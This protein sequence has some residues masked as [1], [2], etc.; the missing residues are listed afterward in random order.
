MAKIN[1]RLY[2]FYSSNIIV[3]VEDAR[4]CESKMT[5]AKKSSL[6]VYNGWGDG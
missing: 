6:I 5:N 4:G 2:D 3:K 1:I